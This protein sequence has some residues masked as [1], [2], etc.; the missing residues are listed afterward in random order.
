[1]PPNRLEE[2]VV[3]IKDSHAVIQDYLS[4]ENQP[5]PSFEDGISPGLQKNTAAAAARQQLLVATEELHALMLG[6]I[7]SFT[8]PSVSNPTD[9]A[10]KKYSDIGTL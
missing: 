2:L 1:M 8:H 5:V 6:P 10:C 4:V 3:T 9:S 7:G